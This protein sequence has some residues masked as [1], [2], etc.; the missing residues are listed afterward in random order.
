[1]ISQMEP[2]TS[3]VVQKLV[4]KFTHSYQR[5]QMSKQMDGNS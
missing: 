1:M 3:S 5:T 2:I 4:L